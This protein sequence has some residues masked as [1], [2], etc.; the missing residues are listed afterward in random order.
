MA[1]V[2]TTLGKYLDDYAANT[3]PFPNP[4]R[5]MDMA[6]LKVIALVQNDK[7]KEIVQAVQLELDG[8]ATGAAGQ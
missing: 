8:K 3:R 2:R 7:T 1:D 5:P 4:N 6:H